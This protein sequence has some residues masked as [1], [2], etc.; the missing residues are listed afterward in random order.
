[1]SIKSLG[2]QANVKLVILIGVNRDQR[3]RVRQE[4]MPFGR[5]GLLLEGDAP[6]NEI[7]DRITQALV[8]PPAQL[9]GGAQ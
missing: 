1:Q 2:A 5:R 8:S 7:K 6:F 4:L 3:D 9:S